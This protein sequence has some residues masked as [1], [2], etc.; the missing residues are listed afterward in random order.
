LSRFSG[1]L[2][3]GPLPIIVLDFSP[4]ASKGCRPLVYNYV[5]KKQICIELVMDT[6]ITI[7]TKNW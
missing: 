7:N 3:Y 5:L 2:I 4:A 1:N 6:E